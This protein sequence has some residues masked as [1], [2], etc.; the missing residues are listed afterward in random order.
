MCLMTLLWAIYGY[1]LVFGGDGPWIGD[2]RYVFMRG[3]DASWTDKGSQLALAPGL[4]I[5]VM[6]P[7]VVSRACSSSSRLP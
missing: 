5:P 7:H 1:S 4:T 3:V 2:L 6:D